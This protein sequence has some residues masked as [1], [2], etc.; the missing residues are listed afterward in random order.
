VD[1]VFPSTDSRFSSLMQTP[2]VVLVCLFNEYTYCYV[3]NIHIRRQG[4]P[5]AS[6]DSGEVMD[7]TVVAE[8][9]RPDKAP[10]LSHVSTS[11]TSNIYQRYVKGLKLASL[12][13]FLF[14]TRIC[15]EIFCSLFLPFFLRWPLDG[16]MLKYRRRYIDLS[17]LTEFEFRSMY[18]YI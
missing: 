7:V 17:R 6:G 13:P 5:P 14:C 10:P 11:F 18:V 2:L 3:R 15:R 12:S 4:L 1:L 9:Q 16:W 8:D